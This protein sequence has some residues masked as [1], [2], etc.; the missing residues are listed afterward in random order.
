M[1]LLLLNKQDM[2]DQMS[3]SS[4][5]ALAE[6]KNRQVRTRK[7]QC[8]SATMYILSGVPPLTNLWCG[9]GLARCSQAVFEPRPFGWESWFSYCCQP[10]PSLSQS[11]K[12]ALTICLCLQSC[13]CT[14]VSIASSRGKGNLPPPPPPRGG[15]AQNPCQ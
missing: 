6:R 5:Q 7:G 3:N 1:L 12:S 11:S 15:P 13:L 8:L 9:K 10:L 14:T 2:K 4:M